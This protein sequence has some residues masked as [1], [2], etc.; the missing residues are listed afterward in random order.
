MPVDEYF[1]PNSLDQA[2]DLLAE[3]QDSLLVMAGGT[4]TMPLI[5]E[6]IS[7][8]EKVM[9]LSHAGLDYIHQSD[10]SVALGA[11]TKLTALLDLESIPILQQA[12]ENTGAWAIRNLGTVGGNLFVPPPSGDVAVALLAL[13]ARVKLVKAGNERWVPINEFFTGFMSNVLGSD[14]LLAEIKVPLP[15]GLTS[16]LKYGRRR[17]NTPSIVTVAANITLAGDRVAEA[18]IA[19]GAVGPHPIRVKSAE[20]ALVG[21]KLDKES[22][23]DASLAASEE[24]QPFT[25]AIASEWYRRKMIKVFVERALSQLAKKEA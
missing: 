9:G 25:D 1:L 20:E 14:E 24:S 23:Q 8:P 16:F 18:R 2:I 13:D 11:T 4:V 15:K 10:E 5:N 21:R 3:H 17:A 6:G 7:V 19:L 12:A 22:I